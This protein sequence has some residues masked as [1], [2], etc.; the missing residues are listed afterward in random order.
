MYLHYSLYTSREIRAM[1]KKHLRALIGVIAG[2]GI[3]AAQSFGKYGVVVQMAFY[4]VIILAIL[5]LGFWEDRQSKGFWIR[6]T[7]AFLFHLIL[8]YFGRGLFPFKSVLIWVPI[9]FIEIILLA[10][11]MIRRDVEEPAT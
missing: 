9:A 5:A 3:A 2:V 8:L 7:L 4:S 6:A 10:A 11:I 1:N